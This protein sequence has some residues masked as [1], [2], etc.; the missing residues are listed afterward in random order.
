[1][2]AYRTQGN[3]RSQVE[4]DVALHVGAEERVEEELL[5]DLLHKV[6]DTIEILNDK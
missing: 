3:H 4:L 1:L 2:I 5:S 6:L